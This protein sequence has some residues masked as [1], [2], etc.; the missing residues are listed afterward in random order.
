M[1]R[2]RDTVEK[3]AHTVGRPGPNV[4]TKII[5]PETNEIVPWGEP[6]EVCARGYFVMKGYW[7]DEEKTRETIDPEHWLHSG[8]LG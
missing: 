7:G 1:S 4:E 6:G 8:D 3:K 2:P 5:N